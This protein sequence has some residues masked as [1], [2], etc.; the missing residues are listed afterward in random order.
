MRLLRETAAT[1]AGGE[2][3]NESTTTSFVLSHGLEGEEVSQRRED[4]SRPWPEA[5]AS[6]ARCCGEQEDKEEEFVEAGICAMVFAALIINLAISLLTM[7]ALLNQQEKSVR[8]YA[9]H[10][11]V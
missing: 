3:L 11:I 8:L 6:N 7:L 1:K 2:I 10:F 9:V 5:R 4:R